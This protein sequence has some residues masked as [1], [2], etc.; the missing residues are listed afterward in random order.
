MM[1]R[2][3]SG[4]WLCVCIGIAVSI[5][6]MQVPFSYEPV[7]PKAF[8]LLLAA[9][10]A[11][12][13]IALIVR[14]DHQPVDVNPALVGKGAALIG[15]LL[16]YALL[17]STIGFVVSTALMVVAVS[18]IFQGSWKTSA[19]TSVTIA[20]VTFLLFDSVLEVSLPR[21]TLLN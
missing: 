19:V 15:V 9:L 7:G 5:W 20:L 8:P 13:S 1:D 6:Q 21:G 16:S 10:M 2:I 17:F 3:F 14:P 4:V 18:R 11:L 12:C